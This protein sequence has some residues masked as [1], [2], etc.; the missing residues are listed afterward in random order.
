MLIEHIDAIANRLG[1]G[2]L[3]VAFGGRPAHVEITGDLD[4]D[5]DWEHDPVRAEVLRRI[6]D[7]GI[8][9]RP[10][11]PVSM[12]GLITYPYEG[13]VFVDVPVDLQHSGYRKLISTL[14]NEDGISEFDTV[15]CYVIRAQHTAYFKP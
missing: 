14:E 3:M 9:Y 11:L 13:H 7:C 10:C 4:A 6:A 5:Y 8:G 1:R 12:T 15:R 2:V